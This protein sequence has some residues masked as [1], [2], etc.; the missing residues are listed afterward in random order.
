MSALLLIPLIAAVGL[1]V[2]AALVAFNR[3]ARRTAPEAGPIDLSSALSACY[4]DLPTKETFAARDGTDLVFRRYLPP[5]GGT[6][7]LIL[8]VHGSAWHGMQ[9]HPLA[10]SLAARGLGT[11][12]APDLRGHGAAPVRRGDVDYIGQFEDD[13]ADLIAFM[14][15]RNRFD[16]VVVGGHSSGGGLVVRLAGGRHRG[17]MDRLILMAP[18]LKYNAPTTKPGS[19][20]WAAPA[21]GRII[22]LG[23]LNAVGV[24]R[25]NH[26]PV[27]AFAMPRQVLDGPYGATVT[28]TY[29]FRLNQSFAPRPDFGKDLAAIT[30]PFL[31]VAG[32]ADEAFH[33]GRYENTV[34]AYT[35]TGT[36]T[37][38]PGIDHIGVTMHPRAV[39]AIAGWIADGDRPVRSADQ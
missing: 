1:L 12:V 29:S 14:G 28:T 23:L 32:A 30:R 8:L 36:Y 10:R 31:L 34:S 19:G 21:T 6:S 7:R 18:F 37:I 11:V 9:F 24:T 15:G 13:I 38:L 2:L 5:A 20:G 16:E 35:K 25:F 33:A 22:G 4:D 17:A 27:I 26:L 3:P 39:D